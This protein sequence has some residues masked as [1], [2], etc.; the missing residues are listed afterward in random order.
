MPSGAVIVSVVGSK[1]SRPARA[2]AMTV[3]GEVTKLSVL[4]EPSLRFGKLRL[5]ELTIVLGRP[6]MLAGRSH[7]PMHGPQAFASTVAPI[8]SRSAMRPSRSIVARVCSEPGVT[9]SSVFALSP[10]AAAWRA[11][12]AARVM[13]SYELL[14][15]LPTRA[16]EISSGQSLARASAPTAAP[17]RLARSGECGPLMSGFNWS[18]SISTS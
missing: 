16:A 3:S 17:T 11:I 4:A 9:S 8:A 18:R 10:L 6:V 1:S 15:Q 5:N 2:R 12:E 14:V 7:C 13:S